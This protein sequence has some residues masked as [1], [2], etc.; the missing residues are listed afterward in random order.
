MSLQSRLGALITAVGTD[1]KALNTL[2]STKSQFHSGISAPASGLGVIGDWYL[3]TPQ[4]KLYEKTGVST[5][6]ERG[7][8]MD[9]SFLDGLTWTTITLASGWTNFWAPDFPAAWAKDAFDMV[10]LRGAVKKSTAVVP[11]ET[12]HTLTTDARPQW[13]ESFSQRSQ[14]SGSAEI[15]GA[16]QIGTSGAI[17]VCAGGPNYLS[18][19][20]SYQ[21][22][23]QIIA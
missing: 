2:V 8:I 14:S 7:A 4:R 6:V 15:Y 19:T 11:Y 13:S 12:I 22:P 17:Q 1:I 3:R 18:L 5:W 21:G 10:H 20:A 9:S 23:T 16:I